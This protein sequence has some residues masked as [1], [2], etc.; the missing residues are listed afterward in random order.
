MVQLSLL[1]TET[2]L[3]VIV[4]LGRGTICGGGTTDDMVSAVADKCTA[5]MEKVITEDFEAL[6]VRARVLKGLIELVKGDIKLA[7]PFFDKSLQ[8]SHATV[9]FFRPWIVLTIC[10][11]I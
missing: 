9:S 3:D 8:P 10:Y 5:L 7:E 11:Y 6:N 2:P 1:A 4:S